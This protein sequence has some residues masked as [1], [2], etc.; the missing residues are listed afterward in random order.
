MNTLRPGIAIFAMIVSALV[1]IA[2][3]VSARTQ[4]GLSMHGT[5]KY[6][7]DSDTLSYVMETAPKGGTL[8][9][10]AVGTF[11]TLNAFTLKGTP[12]LGL[13]YVHDRLMARV[14]D[15]PFS[16]YPLIAE[17]VEVAPDRSAIT[18][19]IDRKA[20]FHDGSAITAQDVAFTFETLKKDGRPNMRRVYALVK[21]VDV[22]SRYKI[23]FTLGEGYDRESVM[24]LAMMPVLSE[25]WWSKR[26]FDAALVE[27]P[28]GS[29]PYKVGKFEL[30][31]NITYVRVKNYWAA[32][33]LA[34]KGLYN[35]DRLNFTYFR[36]DTIALES[37]LKGD[38][39]VRRELDPAKWET[40]YRNTRGRLINKATFKHQR[41]ENVW[42]I[43]LNM[44]DGPLKDVRVRKAL[45]LVLDAARINESLFYDAYLRNASIY[46]NTDLSAP[47]KLSF[48]ERAYLNATKDDQNLPADFEGDKWRPALED[49]ALDLRQRQMEA[50]NLLKDAGFIVLNGA[51]VHIETKEPLT[52]E[53]ITSNPVDER[54]A[55]SWKNQL[56]K[57]GVPLSIRSLDSTSFRNR[58]L[59]YDY[60]AVIHT[61]PSTL[62]PG[63]EQLLYWGC[64]A[65]FDPGR[66]NFTGFCH[67]FADIL[68]AEMADTGKRD[69]L[70]TL[71]RL[72][73]RMVMSSYA[74]IPLYYS[75]RD[76]YALQ[77]DIAVPEVT[78][79][80]GPVI[81]SWWQNNG[82]GIGN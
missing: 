12:A 8:K 32:D 70:I 9:Q 60:Q 47:R 55:L 36:D 29:G 33:K 37:F 35:F 46:P 30:G 41:A 2:Q 58:I 48:E 64:K 62:S 72:L 54:I 66:F 49:D 14:W 13:Q 69:D 76:T 4:F 28:M 18:F 79:M 68:A 57:L 19:N 74:F 52:L 20:R 3:P 24:I 82:V 80:Y 16:L 63:A 42:S 77:S 21:D 56:A 38:V 11:D 34:N 26:L 78:P 50:N 17:N 67:P 15:E 45:G 1:L 71:T 73:D 44:R 5:P 75:P 81:E 39:D 43:F 59:K 7:T 25:K 23:T 31:R 27:A 65:A 22:K 51:R 61:F 53:I 6:K 40:A 10:G